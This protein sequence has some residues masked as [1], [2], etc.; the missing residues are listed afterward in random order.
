MVRPYSNDDYEMICHW[1]EQRGFNP[2]TRSLLPLTGAIASDAACGFLYCTDS[3]VAFID[4]Y[5]TNPEV[6]VSTRATALKDVT[7]HLIR[8][9][10]EM[11]YTVI[12]ANT[13]KRS[14]EN[15]AIE[16]GF[17]N[18]GKHSVLMKEL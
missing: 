5:I 17:K 4:F 18:I 16:H 1:F 7:Q 14:I 2:P 10:K 12:M 9:A 13:Q 15:L 8:W 11:E 6:D 3:D